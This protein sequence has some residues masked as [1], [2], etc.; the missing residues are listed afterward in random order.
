MAPILCP[1]WVLMN[2]FIDMIVII[3]IRVPCPINSFIFLYSFYMDDQPATL[4]FNKRKK[5]WMFWCH[6]H[7]KRLSSSRTTIPLSFPFYVI[8]HFFYCISYVNFYI[9]FWPRTPGACFNSFKKLWEPK[10]RSYQKKIKPIILIFLYNIIWDLWKKYDNTVLAFTQEKLVLY[11]IYL[12]CFP[13]KLRSKYVVH[14][15]IFIIS[16]L[17]ESQLKG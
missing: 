17:R 4:S 2:Y 12:G 10:L 5:K 1:K 15:K 14:I 13:P 3:I 11:G 7:I 8:F 6:T 9:Y 16:F